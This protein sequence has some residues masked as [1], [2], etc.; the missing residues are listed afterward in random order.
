M[1]RANLQAYVAKTLETHFEHA[2]IEPNDTPETL[3]YVL[4]DAMQYASDATQKAVAIREAKQL[5]IDRCAYLGI[6]APAFVE[7]NKDEVTPDVG[8]E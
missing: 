4:N 5:L 7:E 3:L 6:Q 1:K 8:N 2:M